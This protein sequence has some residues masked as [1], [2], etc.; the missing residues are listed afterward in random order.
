MTSSAGT[1]V[2]EPVGAPATTP[3]P[4]AVVAAHGELAA[5]LVSA[6]EQIT[7][8]G[9]VFV[10]LSNRDLSSADLEA[11]IEEHV[12][13]GARVVFT[14]LPAG[15]TTIC[16]RRLQRAHPDLVV[17]TGA[18][19]A[20]LLAFALAADE[21]PAAAARLAAEKARAAMQVVEGP[22]AAAAAAAA[23]HAPAGAS[24]AA[25]EGS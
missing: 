19:L 14:D 9:A 23:A 10:A 15:S 17:V 8:R 5:G 25:P 18:S 1:P 4:R 22:G 6:V 3:A 20:A 24:A 2:G 11:R 7:G 21:P 16:A 12:A 13:R